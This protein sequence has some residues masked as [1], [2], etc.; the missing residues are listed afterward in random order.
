MYF[1]WVNC[2]P[3]K[4]ILYS[5][6]PFTTENNFGFLLHFKIGATLLNKQTQ[7]RQ[8]QGQWDPKQGVVRWLLSEASSRARRHVCSPGLTSTQWLSPWA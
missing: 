3:Q 6:K 8:R 5:H 4:S 1:L 7:A 2:L